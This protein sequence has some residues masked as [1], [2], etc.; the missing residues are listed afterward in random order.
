MIKLPDCRER[1]LQHVSTAG[2]DGG[3]H[4]F[5]RKMH[6]GSTSCY[7]AA[8]L[9]NRRPKGNGSYFF[10]SWLEP[11]ARHCNCSRRPDGKVSRVTPEDLFQEITV[12]VKQLLCS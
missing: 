3:G 12:C 8:V 5:G 2:H 9:R 1:S 6:T 10:L 7:V 4:Y 11:L